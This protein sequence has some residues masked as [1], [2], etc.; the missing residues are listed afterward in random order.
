MINQQWAFNN[1]HD[2][3][4]YQ[5]MTGFILDTMQVIFRQ[6]TGSTYRPSKTYPSKL[7]YSS[8]RNY[9]PLVMTNIAMV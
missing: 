4:I 6:E 1:K 2:D 8:V 9:Y 7:Y 5:T 3:T